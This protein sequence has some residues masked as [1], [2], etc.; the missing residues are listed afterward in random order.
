VQTA[1]KHRAAA[2]EMAKINIALI[3]NW[4]TE[5]DAGYIDTAQLRPD[6]QIARVVSIRDQ[7]STVYGAIDLADDGTLLG[8]EIL[9]V[10]KVIP[11][12]VE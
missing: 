3:L 1:S 5:S 2:A 4:D 8:I 6:R 12:A 9:Q 10:R 7:H 11:I